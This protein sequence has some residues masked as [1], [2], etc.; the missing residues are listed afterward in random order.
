M[1]MIMHSR[2]NNPAGVLRSV[3]GLKTTVKFLVKSNSKSEFEEPAFFLSLTIVV[4]DCVN[5]NYC[6]LILTIKTIQARQTTEV[7]VNSDTYFLSRN[8][9]G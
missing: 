1:Y 8:A 3:H 2:Y 6:Q 4:I 7:E 9:D 5:C